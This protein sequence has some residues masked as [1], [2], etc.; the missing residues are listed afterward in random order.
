MKIGPLDTPPAATPPSTER[1]TS[2]TTAGRSGTAGSPSSATVDISAAGS[3][4][5]QSASEPTFDAAKVDRI[6]TA[7]REG[8]FTVDANKIADKLISNAQDL[9]KRYTQNSQ[10]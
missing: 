5:A 7:I 4:L 10:N 6:A 9:L 2:S 3:Q 8:K 1:K